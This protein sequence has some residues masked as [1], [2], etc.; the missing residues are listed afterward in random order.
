MR[1][2]VSY[3]A[4]V[5]LGVGLAL[6][7]TPAQAAPVA[8]NFYGSTGGTLFRVFDGTVQSDLT[9]QSAVFGGGRSTSSKNSTAG[10][11][12]GDLAK[13]GVVETT[14]SANVNSLTGTTLRSWARTEGVSL[15]GGLITAD[16]VETTI[17][18]TGRPDGSVGHTAATK[19]VNIKIVGVDL[20]VNI[21]RNYQVTIPG[22]ATVT[23][24]FA[25]H[26]NVEEVTGTVGWAIGVQLLKAR[27]GYPSRATVMVNPVNQY[28]SEANPAN[29]ASLAGNA[30]GTRVRA[31]SGDGVKIVSDPTAQVA[32][33]TG[34][35]GG[36]T[37]NNSVLS[38]RVPG[39]LT[40]GVV[41]SATTSTN[42]AFGNAE[43]VNTNQT[44]GLNLL[45]GLIKADAIKVT[46]SNRLLDRVWTHAE[47]FKLVNLVIAGRKI[48]V[49]V[50]PNT[51]VD[52]ADLGEVT[53]NYQES[54][55]HGSYNTKVAGLR[56]VLD[57]ARAGL[58]VGA[59]VE[60]AVAT[61][62]IAP[63][64]G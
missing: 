50:S 2:I 21:P 5:L 42:D 3:L 64:V 18:T 23:L 17:T 34:S 63:P 22:I 6:P 28:L 51:S 16:A 54:R 61:T 32:T 43:V 4:V 39:L 46:A 31:E 13:V 26:G 41:S 7:A 30:Y 15:L 1:R 48:P 10:V 56:I 52:V 57:T 33:P 47:E 14:T 59:V 40:T 27:A 25:L 38:T 36:R 53:I 58:P 35:S 49:D 24:N 9:A 62:A 44:A 19:L 8:W 60:V 55:Y 45:G 37:L 29:T 11:E 20:P 12:V